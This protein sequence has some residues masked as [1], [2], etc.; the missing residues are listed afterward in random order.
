MLVKVIVFGL[1][2]LPSGWL[3]KLREVVD[4]RTDVFGTATEIVIVWVMLPLLAMMVIGY[5]PDGVLADVFTVKTEVEEVVIVA[6]L[7]L[8]VAPGILET[9][10]SVKLT[11][12]VIPP[13]GSVAR[14]QVAT[15]AGLTLTG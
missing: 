5:V 4:K 10:S 8:A 7:R 9:P 11:L 3:P 12:P 14:F 6:G 1:L 13:R 2:V 15:P